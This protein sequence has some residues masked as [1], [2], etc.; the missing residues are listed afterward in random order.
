MK[1]STSRFGTIEVRGDQVFVFPDGLIGFPHL[2]HVVLLADEDE[3]RVIWLQALADP[4]LAFA[5]LNPRD[6]V[7]DYRIR[8]TAGQLSPLARRSG[9]PLHALALLNAKGSH[10]CVNLKAPILIDQP[11][12]LGCQ[13]VTLDEWPIAY[14]IAPLPVSLCRQSA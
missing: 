14:P 3:P 5:T 1:I 7:R 9:M 8:V 6:V 2:R 4:R 13:V 12:A 10:L 11:N